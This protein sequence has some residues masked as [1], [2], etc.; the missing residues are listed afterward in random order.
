MLPV[1]LLLSLIV[2]YAVSKQKNILLQCYNFPKSDYIVLFHAAIGEEVIF[3]IAPSLIFPD[4]YTTRLFISTF[5]FSSLHSL[6][7]FSGSRVT[8]SEMIMAVNS[9]FMLA[10]LMMILEK[11]MPSTLWW[12]VFCCAIHIANNLIFVYNANSKIKYNPGMSNGFVVKLN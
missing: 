10:S 9:T 6:P 11:Y 2:N 3:R 8:L 5:V 4:C 7:Y 12:Y 1:V